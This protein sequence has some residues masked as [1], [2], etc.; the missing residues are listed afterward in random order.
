MFLFQNK[1]KKYS[2]PFDSSI[3]S[4]ARWFVSIVCLLNK[5]KLDSIKACIEQDEYFE[6]RNRKEIDQNYIESLK[7][8]IHNRGKLDHTV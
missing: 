4:K 7:H 5:I 6:G 8:E 1:Y 3:S 2:Q